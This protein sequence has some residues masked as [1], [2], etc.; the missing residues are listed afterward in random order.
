MTASY[1]IATLTSDGN[2]W[3]SNPL[4]LS[5]NDLANLDSHVR[6]GEAQTRQEVILAKI[7]QSVEEQTE[8][9]STS[10]L[11]LGV[12][13]GTEEGSVYAINTRYVVAVEVVY[14]EEQ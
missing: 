3:M 8:G 4:D 6:N 11:N 2:R 9:G 1:Q 13:T 7:L 5:A 12:C 14:T 10:W